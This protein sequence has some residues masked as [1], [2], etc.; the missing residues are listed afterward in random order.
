[1]FRKISLANAGLVIGFLLT[2]LGFVAYYANWAALNIGSLFYGVGILL[3]G[4]ALKSSELEPLPY[5][6]PTP[7]S[8]LALREKQATST[9]EQIIK[10]VTRFRYGQEVH[11][12]ESLE[13][14][15]L[16][17]SD[18]ERPLLQSLR[19]EERDGAYALVLEFDSPNTSLEVWQKKQEKIAKFFGPG[20]RAE[21]AQP[22]DRRVDVALVVEESDRT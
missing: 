17:P 11:L 19:E 7:E 1:M 3:A 18:E 20:I 12:E 5:S 16:S 2:S 4:F 14:L 8:T 22:A 9:Q 13:R 15:G 21:I 6:K 10:D